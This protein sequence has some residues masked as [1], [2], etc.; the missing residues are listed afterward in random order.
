MEQRLQNRNPKQACIYFW[1][2]VRQLLF[3]CGGYNLLFALFHLAFWRLFG[4]RQQLVKLHPANRAIMQILNLRLIYVFLLFGAVYL[5]FPGQLAGT[6][7]G[8]FLMAGI[9]LFWLGRL[10]EQ[11]IF[12]R[13]RAWQV[14]LLTLIFVLGV[15]LHGLAWWLSA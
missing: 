11:F 1:R 6:A 9:T 2:M 10:V 5:V 12:L 14:H 13:M 15:A 4:W 7:L 8:R 3:A